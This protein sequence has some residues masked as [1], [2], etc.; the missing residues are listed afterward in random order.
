LYFFLHINFMIGIIYCFR[1]FYSISKEYSVVPIFNFIQNIMDQAYTI[2]LG[3]ATG[4]PKTKLGASLQGFEFL[5]CLW[6]II[7]LAKQSHLELFEDSFLSWQNI[8]SGPFKTTL[9]FGHFVLRPLHKFH[10]SKLRL[11]LCSAL[12]FSTSLCS[13]KNLAKRTW[14]FF[15]VLTILYSTTI[16][17]FW[18]KGT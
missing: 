7:S 11:H 8:L 17:F 14:L 10:N 3:S 18:L 4:L 13:V 9:G 2:R 16:V 5:S 12:G 15:R 1:L 6:V